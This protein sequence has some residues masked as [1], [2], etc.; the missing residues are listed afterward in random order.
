[1]TPL[2]VAFQQPLVRVWIT[3]TKSRNA[4]TSD[5]GHC[6]LSACSCRVGTCRIGE[7]KP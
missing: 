1:M 5:N 7:E 2:G 3:F 6:N 4:E